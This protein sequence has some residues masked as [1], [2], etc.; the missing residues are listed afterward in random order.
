MPK[1][2]IGSVSFMNDAGGRLADRLAHGV[3]AARR[4]TSKPAPVDAEPPRSEAERELMQALRRV[5]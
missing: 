1:K 2:I 3:E 5:K 4:Q